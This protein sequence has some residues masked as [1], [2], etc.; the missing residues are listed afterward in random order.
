MQ[1]WAE[2]RDVYTFACWC[3]YRQTWK[4]KWKTKTMRRQTGS[5]GSRK[6]GGFFPA[7]IRSCGRFNPA[8][9]LLTRQINAILKIH[10]I[11]LHL[12][13]CSH[14]PLK[15]S[16][17]TWVEGSPSQLR[18]GRGGCCD[19]VIYNEKY[20]FGLSSHLQHKTPKI[21]GISSVKRGG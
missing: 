16:A 11:A 9:V 17:C 15:H 14:L 12:R 7:P 4:D 1:N 18:D 20:V 13:F 6:Q 19:P 10:T 3:A 8:D 5:S 2:G 21:F